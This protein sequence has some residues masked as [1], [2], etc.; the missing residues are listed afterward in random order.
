MKSESV[1]IDERTIAVENASVRT[2]YLILTY[3]ILLDIVYR[4]ALLRE[5]AWDLMALVGGAGA[6]VIIQQAVHRT[7]SRYWIL[8]S[9]TIA[10][11][12]AIVAIAIV[13]L[14]H[15]ARW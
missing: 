6:I 11:F 7:L 15:Q 13:F 10:F 1:D 5:A 9:V 4:G 3:G 14:L 8:K 2:G 12:S